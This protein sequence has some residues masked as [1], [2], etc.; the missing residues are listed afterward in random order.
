MSGSHS[1][2]GRPALRL[3]HAEPDQVPR[4]QEFRGEHPEVIIGTD[5]FG[6]WQGRIPE[7]S[8]E[9]VL[10]RHLLRELLDKLGQLLANDAAGD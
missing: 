1:G 10:N 9:T 8:G 3:I 6:N 4:L 7:P 2:P 5:E